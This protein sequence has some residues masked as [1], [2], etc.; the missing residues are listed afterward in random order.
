MTVRTFLDTSFRSGSEPARLGTVSAAASVSGTATVCSSRAVK[1]SPTNR[2]AIRG[3]FGRINVTSLPSGPV[4]LG[5]RTEPVEE[6]EDGRG[7]H[8]RAPALL[9]R[10][11]D[12]R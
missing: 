6:L 5:R 2:S 8:S 7:P 10:R 12:L 9:Q 1:V 11:E 3:A 4:D